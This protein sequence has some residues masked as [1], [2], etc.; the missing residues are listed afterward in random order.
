M[1]FIYVY[2]LQSGLATEH[3]YIGRTE[4]LHA[5]LKKHNAGEVPHTLPNSGR[6]KSKPQLPLANAPFNLKFISN[7]P[8]TA[9][10]RK[11]DCKHVHATAPF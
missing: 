8:L 7:P 2:I 4:D 11:N 9:R 6:G 5:R 1:Q 10:L 3:F